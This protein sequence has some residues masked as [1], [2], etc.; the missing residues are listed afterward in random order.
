VLAVGLF[1]LLVAS[2]YSYVEEIKDMPCDPC[3]TAPC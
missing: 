2:L 1:G 3:V